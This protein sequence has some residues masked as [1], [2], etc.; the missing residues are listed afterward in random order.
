VA[1]YTVVNPG[2]A[3]A[4]PALV[5]VSAS[6]TWANNGAQLL[7]VHNGNAGATTVTIVDQ[8]AALEAIEIPG[9]S[10]LNGNV[11]I[12]VPAGTDRYIGPLPVA[13]FNDTS[14]LTTVTYSVTAS[15]T[16]EVIDAA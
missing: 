11:V 9:A 5:A 13:R 15:V 1:A 16:A 8:Q 7:H 3:G 2:Y 4:A 10:A 12:S 14:G 6:D